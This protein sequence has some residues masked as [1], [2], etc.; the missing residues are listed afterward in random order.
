VQASRVRQAD[1]AAG[2]ARVSMRAWH[3]NAPTCS[4]GSFTFDNDTTRNAGLGTVDLLQGNTR[5]TFD[6]TV[7]NPSGTS[8]VGRLAW[9]ASTHLLTISGTI[10]IDGGLNF[11]GQSQANYTG[12][13]TIYANG[14]VGTAGQS[15]ICGHRPRCCSRPA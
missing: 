10:F 12:F 6:C 9:N 4:V 5:P 15:A 2:G 13:G 14:S 11:S 8:T 3:W 7:M 1:A